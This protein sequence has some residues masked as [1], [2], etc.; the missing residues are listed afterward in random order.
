MAYQVKVIA[1]L[2]MLGWGE[3][4][5]ETYNIQT[6][7]IL[8]LTDTKLTKTKYAGRAGSVKL[9]A[10]PHGMLIS[11]AEGEQSLL[12]IYVTQ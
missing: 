8:Q 3:T 7:R 11:C 6:F 1:E 9:G 12:I 4:G 10:P 5:H 2:K